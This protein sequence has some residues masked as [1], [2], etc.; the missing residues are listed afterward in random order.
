[1]PPRDVLLTVGSEMLEATMSY[2]CRW[3]EYLNYRPLMQQYFNEDPNFRHESAPKPR[4]TD[5][6]YHPDYL[7]DRIGVEKRLRWAA[8]KFFVTTEE[9]PLFDAADV[10]RLG[11]DLVVQHGFTTNQKGIE[12]S[13]GTDGKLSMPPDRPTTRRRHCAIPRPGCR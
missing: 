7:S 8:E 4:L 1:M 13:K 5:A 6:D 12:W 3:F 10:L 9:E 11:R 2:R